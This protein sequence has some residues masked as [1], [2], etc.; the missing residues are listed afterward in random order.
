MRACDLEWDIDAEMALVDAVER[1]SLGWTVI[2]ERH[3]A[4]GSSSAPFPSDPQNHYRSHYLQ[5]NMAKVTLAA[6]SEQPQIIDWTG[7]PE[8]HYLAGSPFREVSKG[9]VV[10]D[11]QHQSAT[12][13]GLRSACT[14]ESGATSTLLPSISPSYQTSATPTGYMCRRPL[15]RWRHAEL[16]GPGIKGSKVGDLGWMP[17]RDEFE[18]EYA[19]SADKMLN[20]LVTLPDD[21]YLQKTLFVAQCRSYTEV[22]AERE[23]RKSV[24]KEHGLTSKFFQN[25][26]F[27]RIRK[28]KLQSSGDEDNTS[29]DVVKPL[30]D[31]ALSTEHSVV[32]NMEV[33][34]PQP[35][36]HAEQQQAERHSVQQLT[37]NLNSR[38]QNKRWLKF[39]Q[40][41]N[42]SAF[43]QIQ[44]DITE[45]KLLLFR[46][47]Q[48]RRW[49]RRGLR[50][51]TQGR[52]YE[53]QRRI[54]QQKSHIARNRMSHSPSD[55]IGY[56]EETAS[57]SVG[58]VHVEPKTTLLSQSEQA[59]LASHNLSEKSYL[60]LK[61][62]ALCRDVSNC[63]VNQESAAPSSIVPSSCLSSDG[64]PAAAAALESWVQVVDQFLNDHGLTARKL[65][66]LSME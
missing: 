51:K 61:T 11:E 1:Y 15:P 20:A 8:T 58:V 6:F 13:Y 24:I 18:R 65:A 42:K 30:P 66:K 56:A 45:F 3:S 46:V 4:P 41:L 43:V 14:S 16:C 19:D 23:R 17:L 9:A 64:T 22:V 47:R 48:L 60:L 25:R 63:A 52:D 50:S 49:R 40:F 10:V 62:A 53:R 34:E 36:Q 12:E 33:E 29:D 37:N 21:G 38:D 5:G 39:G 26:N 54:D 27:R 35:I 28:R 7:G 2:K 57:G 44:Q 31:A 59:L 55:L 32:K